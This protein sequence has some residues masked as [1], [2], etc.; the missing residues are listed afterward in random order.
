MID[1]YFRNGYA[2][3]NKI[4]TGKINQTFHNYSPTNFLWP[5]RAKEKRQIKKSFSYKSHS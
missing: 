2:E 4:R 5:N 1:S 3:N